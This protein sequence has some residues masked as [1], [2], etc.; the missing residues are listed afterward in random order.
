MDTIFKFKQFSIKQDATAMKVGTDGVLLGAW[1]TVK[2]GDLLDIGTGTGLI[3]LML[4]QQ[5]QT[6]L[7]DAIEIEKQAYTQAL[8]NV[9]NCNWTDRITVHHCSIQNFKSDKK[10]DIIISNPPFFIDSTKAPDTQRNTARHTDNLSFSDLINSVNR[11]LKSDG[12]FSLILPIAEAQQFIELAKQQHLFLN[13]ECFIKPNPRKPAKRILM[14]FS[15]RQKEITKTTLTIETET[16]HQYTK[17]YISLTK[18][19][20]LNF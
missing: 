16:R 8:E 6:A 9:N 5:T 15:F 14:E 7:I 11:L 1:S 20:Y 2:E 18:E 19:F 17:E 10:Y 3:G 12:L 13:R 4:A